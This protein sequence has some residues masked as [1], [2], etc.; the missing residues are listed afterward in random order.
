MILYK[1]IKQ[2]FLEFF[3][4]LDHKIL[5][6]SS[7]TQTGDESVL[8]T[9]AGMQQFK[10]YYTGDKDPILD[11]SSK[12][13]ISIQK[14]FRLSDLENIGDESHLSFFEM[15]GNFSFG[16]YFKKETI[17]WAYNFLSQVLGVE[18]S[19]IK[20]AVFQGN[21]DLNEDKDS[22]ELLKSI[23]F[24]DSKIERK[25]ME[26]NF[27]GP[28]GITGPCGPTVE[29]YIDDLEVWNLVFNEYFKKEDGSYQKLQK[30]GVDT[31]MG[32]ERLLYKINN[33]NNIFESELFLPLI[34]ILRSKNLYDLSSENLKHERIVS[35]HLKG[36]AFLISEG[37][38]P[39]NIKQGYILRRILRR[40]FVHL[41]ALNLNDDIIKEVVLKVKEI[42]A[43]F[44]EDLNNTDNIIET[45]LD[46]KLKFAK[47]LNNGLKEFEK[48][49][50]KSQDKKLDEELAFNLYQSYG[51]PRDVILDLIKERGL[52]FDVEIFNKFFKEHQEKSRKIEEKKIG[53]I[54]QNP[55]YYEIKLHTATHLLHK[56][57]RDL[58]GD[59]LRQMGSD[60]NEKRLRFDFNL[61]RALSHEEIKKVEKAVNSKIKEDLDV[62]YLEMPLKKAIDSGA[63]SFF[64]EKYP[65][66]VKVYFIGNYSKEICNG[67]H[68]KK[69]SELKKFE[70]IKEEGIG[71]G[72]RR[73][74]SIIEK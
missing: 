73:I 58:F 41:K 22:I 19:R 24:E 68:V 40:S 17:D 6:S 36:A 28:T 71:S 31:G 59:D 42:Y 26:D 39:S 13:V 57:L 29:F 30:P 2:K 43:E 56:A 62:T 67:P 37:L 46:E 15:L 4:N 65:S 49:V 33:L 54:R 16:D 32:I 14:C 69:T 25:G 1:D 64:K 8:L 20:T 50:K 45:I 53:G 47:V 70:I 7:L 10:A 61:K 72:L 12:R 9:T 35:D 21:K 44:Y 3:R 18:K 74:K 11:F 34:E 48:I 66:E 52:D 27:W 51:F 23:G 55:T 5:P 38:I 63:M 60:I